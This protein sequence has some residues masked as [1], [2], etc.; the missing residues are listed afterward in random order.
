MEVAPV[1]VLEFDDVSLCSE[2]NEGWKD[3]VSHV[4]KV[5]SCK[6]AELNGACRQ[7][8]VTFLVDKR[9]QVSF[10]A[11]SFLKDKS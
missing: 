9:K 11:T 4:N 8:G 1:E 2:R 3:N 5:F 10:V 6:W 7:W